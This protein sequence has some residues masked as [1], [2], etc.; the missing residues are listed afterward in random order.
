MFA[1]FGWNG[2]LRA[3]DAIRSLCAPEQQNRCVVDETAVQPA[4]ACLF[5]EGGDKVMDSNAYLTSTV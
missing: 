3:S 1:Q 5:G 4:P 2:A